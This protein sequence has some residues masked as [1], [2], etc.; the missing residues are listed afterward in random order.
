MTQQMSLLEGLKR[1]RRGQDVAAAHNPRFELACLAAQMMA[2]QF[3][4]VTADDISEAVEG[5]GAATGA[6][7]RGRE[8]EFTGEWRKSKRV[9]NHARMNRVWRLRR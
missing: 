6:I 8:W 3:G 1:K 4:E 2:Q 7:F 5:L 9:S